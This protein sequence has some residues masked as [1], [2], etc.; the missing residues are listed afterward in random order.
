MIARILKSRIVLMTGLILILLG[1]FD[2]L[3]GAV[4]ILIG[5]GL[6]ALNAGVNQYMNR[7]ILYWALGLAVMGFGAMVVLSMFGGIGGKSGRSMWWGVLILP[8][9]VGWIMG[10]VGGF[11]MLIDFIKH[12]PR[13]E[14]ETQ[15]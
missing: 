6:A 10:L 8:Y 3:E 11:R 12:P 4:V 7:K 15:C 9:P 13:K 14:P 2:P 5:I 1:I